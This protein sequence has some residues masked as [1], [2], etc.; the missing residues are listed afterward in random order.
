MS[1]CV[2]GQ[3]PWRRRRL[4][5]TLLLF[6]RLC[7]LPTPTSS[8]ATIESISLAR[9]ALHSF[10]SLFPPLCA[11]NR[12]S[13]FVLCCLVFWY[14]I[15]SHRT[16]LHRLF[17]PVADIPARFA[18]VPNHHASPP[19][20]RPRL[21]TKVV[22]CTGTDSPARASISTT[23]YTPHRFEPRASPLASSLPNAAAPCVAWQYPGY[24]LWALVRQ[25][26][27]QQLPDAHAVF[28]PKNHPSLSNGNPDSRLF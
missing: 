12:Q 13:A 19:R 15:S 11:V 23:L 22:R 17:L 5:P 21:T 26:V 25:S 24:R 20:P 9:L 2:A 3:S 18:S 8:A 10:F 1:V 16:A 14:R 28:G 27:Q 6:S 7:I 4:A